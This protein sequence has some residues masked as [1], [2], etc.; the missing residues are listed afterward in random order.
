MFCLRRF[1]CWYGQQPCLPLMCPSA[2]NETGLLISTDL[3][4]NC[5]VL[6]IAKESGPRDTLH[7]RFSESLFMKWQPRIFP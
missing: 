1:L 6:S 5:C 3:Q 2:L 7:Q 4:K